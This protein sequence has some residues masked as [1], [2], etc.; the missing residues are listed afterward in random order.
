MATPT[1]GRRLKH[2]AAFVAIVWGVAATFV[3]FDLIALKGVDFVVAYQHLFGNVLL[4]PATS[5]SVTCVVQPDEQKEA[6]TIPRDAA[7]ARVGA[8]T[9]GLSFGRDAVFRQYI[10]A[11]SPELAELAASIE[12]IAGRLE[13]AAPRSFVPEQIA[14]AIREFAA[15]VE[16][17]GQGTAHELA[18][19][20][21][22]QA[23]QVYKLGALW[24]Y[25]EVVRSMIPGEHAVFAVEINHYAPRAALPDA[26]W[27]PMLAPTPRQA[28]TEELQAAS[29]A[30]TDGITRYLAGDR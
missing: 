6:A 5:Q 7:T 24:G 18:V 8:W 17:D 19:K 20:Y 27:R 16:A 21:T 2:L 1:L 26:L 15:F 28:T 25:S 3:A 23:C 4:S 22:P 30:L 12:E 11:D 14:N 29:A 9:L 10:P 13:V